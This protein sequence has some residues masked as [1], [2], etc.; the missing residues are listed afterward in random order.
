MLIKFNNVSFPSVTL[1]EIIY[2]AAIH[3]IY[4]RSNI[5]LFI[6]NGIIHSFVSITLR[7]S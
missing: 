5:N 4:F 1:Y 7:Y 2:I 6:F 3:E